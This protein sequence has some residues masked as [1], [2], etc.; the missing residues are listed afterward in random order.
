VVAIRKLNAWRKINDDN[1][2]GN[3]NLLALTEFHIGI[4]QFG[5]NLTYRMSHLFHLKESFPGLQP[6]AI[7]SLVLDHFF[8]RM[9][10]IWRRWLS[11]SGFV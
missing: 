5:N 3:P 4:A 7:C 8:E 11:G 6:K 10:N 2:N 1:R 9:V